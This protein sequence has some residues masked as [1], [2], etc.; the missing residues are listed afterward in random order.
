MNDVSKCAFTGSQVARPSV[1][2]GRE[3]HAGYREEGA[4]GGRG[5]CMLRYRVS[6]GT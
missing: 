4:R 3:R 1:G 6:I 5:L 2:I